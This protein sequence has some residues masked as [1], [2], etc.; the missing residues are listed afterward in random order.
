MRS[1][2]A[3]LAR[4]PLRAPR[5]E[6]GFTIIELMVASGVI[7]L[8]MTSLAYVITQSLTDV[9]FER[10]RQT[11]NGLLDR[12]IEQVRALRFADVQNGLQTADVGSSDPNL[13]SCTVNGTP[14]FCYGGEPIVTTSSQ[15]QAPLFPHLST[16]NLN[17]DAY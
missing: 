17:N 7:L 8:V 1:A 3:W 9:G 15:S 4:R 16:T 13:T 12:T 6:D 11:A 14:A 5:S 10:Q 2:R